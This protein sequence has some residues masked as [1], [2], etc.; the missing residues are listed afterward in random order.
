MRV[1]E[2]SEITRA[3]EGLA[4]DANCRLGDDVMAR[5]AESASAEASPIGRETLGII[6]ENARV[7]AARGVPICQDTGMAVVFAEVGQDVRINGDFASAVNRGVS[8][9]YRRRGFRMSV[10]GDPLLR[11]N[12]GDNTPAVV[13]CEL[14]PGDGLKVTFMPKGFGSENMGCVRMLSPSDGEGGVVRAVVEC[15]GAAGPNPCPPLI[16]GVGL[17][18]TMDKAV[19]LA[20][21]ALLRECGRHSHLP[22]VKALEEK[23]LRLI[24]GLGIGPAGTGGNVT[25]LAVHVETYPTHIAGLPVAVSLGCHANR[26][27]TAWL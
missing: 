13:H 6:A 23:A 8:E 10:V 9:A 22:H 25:A 7:A 14:V 17:G 16:V 3:I 27:A 5:I 26:H 20:K 2:A 24:N 21:K 19:L 12:T 18:G 11:T 1:V 15:V 4:Y